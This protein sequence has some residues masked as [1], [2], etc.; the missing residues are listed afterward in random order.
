MNEI[1]EMQ[2]S[3]FAFITN[4]GPRSNPFPSYPQSPNIPQ[5]ILFFL[6]T[7]SEKQKPNENRKSYI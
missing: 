7:L 6:Y 2:N 4:L 1:I 5:L 3:F